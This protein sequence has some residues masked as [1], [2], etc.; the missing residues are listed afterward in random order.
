MAKG[1]LRRTRVLLDTRA[2]GHV[3]LPRVAAS[4]A[5]RAVSPHARAAL[6]CARLSCCNL[7]A[8]LVH[9]RTSNSCATGA[10]FIAHT[11]PCKSIV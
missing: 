8:R 9:C 5:T 7:M 10:T 4:H 1:A 3:P 11:C 2:A 6:P